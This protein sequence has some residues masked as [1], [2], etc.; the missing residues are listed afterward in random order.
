[1]QVLN[2]FPQTLFFSDSLGIWYKDYGSGSKLP[3]KREIGLL[4]KCI[5]VLQVQIMFSEL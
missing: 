1:M 3:F 4:L 5:T 2:V